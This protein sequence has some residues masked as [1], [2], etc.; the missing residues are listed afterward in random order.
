MNP[1]CLSGLQ[2]QYLWRN[3]FGVG[4]RFIGRLLCK[5]KS[6]DE[7]GSYGCMAISHISSFIKSFSDNGVSIMMDN[8]A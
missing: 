4:A 7:S 2:G 1:D 5:E 3:A 6:P 8:P